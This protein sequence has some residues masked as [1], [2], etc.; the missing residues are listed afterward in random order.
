MIGGPENQARYPSVDDII[1]TPQHS[2]IMKSYK[3]PSSPSFNYEYSKDFPSQGLGQEISEGLPSA[4]QEKTNPDEKDELIQKLMNKIKKQA[5]TI[6]Q[7]ESN[8]GTFENRNQQ[9]GSNFNFANQSFE[10]YKSTSNSN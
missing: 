4:T 8:K 7:I 2:S 5:D 10:N 1:P 9:A 3:D 6:A